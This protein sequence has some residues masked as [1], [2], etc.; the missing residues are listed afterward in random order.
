MLGVFFAVFTGGYLVVIAQTD[1]QTL[2]AA[3][4]GFGHMAEFKGRSFPSGEQVSAE[5]VTL[6]LWALAAMLTPW[7]GRVVDWKQIR[8]PLTICAAGLAAV[9]GFHM[10]MSW[11]EMLH[12]AAETGESAPHGAALLVT[13]A[14]RM[15][16]AV[17]SHLFP[18]LG[19]ALMFAL[20][21]W[22]W[23][24]IANIRLR[25][26]VLLLLGLCLAARSR[27]LASLVLW[28]NFLLELPVF[29]LAAHLLMPKLNWKPQRVLRLAFTG[30]FAVAAF[31]YWSLSVGALTRRGTLQRVQTA[32]GNVY[33]APAEAVRYARMREA[34]EKIDPL[35]ARPLFAFG[36]SGGYNYFYGRRNPTPT[37]QGFSFSKVPPEQLVSELLRQFPATIIIDT[38]LYDKMVTPVPEFHPFRWNADRRPIH[39]VR[40]DR[41]Y[42]GRITQQ[43]PQVAEVQWPGPAP[44]RIHDCQATGVAFDNSRKQP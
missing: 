20:V 34:L 27:R 21:V 42:F 2:L 31:S 38:S 29:V 44:F 3:L 35:G 7:L 23:K 10:W 1:F 25:N 17:Q 32:Q 41:Q 22:R 26:A 18:F 39:F 40:F 6:G 19:P 30:L 11:R 37:S 9:A 43:C 12:Y 15:R 28:F 14:V 24:K 16:V 5:I 13:L 36:S 8:K 33:L 4:G